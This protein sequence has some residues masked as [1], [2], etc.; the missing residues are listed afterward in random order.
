MK[1]G[2][3]LVTFGALASLAACSK[4]STTG[5]KVSAE[6]F[7]ETIS[8]IEEHQYASVHAKL[9][10]KTNYI[11]KGYT[12]DEEETTRQNLHMNDIE[13]KGFEADF[14]Y[15]EEQ[16]DWVPVTSSQYDGYIYEELYANVNELFIEMEENPESGATYYINPLKVITNATGPNGQYQKGTIVF[17]KY[18]YLTSV[19]SDTYMIIMSSQDKSISVKSILSYT[20]K[21]AD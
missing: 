3:L 13:L 20:A 5:T 17:D 9:N 1:L 11:F 16:E 12:A 7:G 8:S 14:T 18:G 2:K 6:K 15:S 10:L 4:E 19:N 21:Y